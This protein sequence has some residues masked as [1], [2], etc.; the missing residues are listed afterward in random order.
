MH[1]SYE[2]LKTVQFLV[3]TLKDALK[4]CMMQSH[5]KQYLSALYTIQTI[6]DSLFT[7]RISITVRAVVEIINESENKDLLR[8]Y[9]KWITTQRAKVQKVKHFCSKNSS[10]INQALSKVP[11]PSPQPKRRNIK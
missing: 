9:G 5:A 11:P 10:K 1:L 3:N 4:N 7:K 8:L 2:D 6:D